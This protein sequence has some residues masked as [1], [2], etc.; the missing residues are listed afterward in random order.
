MADVIQKALYLP[1]EVY[2]A[3]KHVLTFQIGTQE[4]SLNSDGCKEYSYSTCT[5]TPSISG[6]DFSGHSFEA[7]VLSTTDS[8]SAGK[9]NLDVDTSDLSTGTVHVTISKAASIALDNFVPSTNS[10]STYNVG[11]WYLKRTDPSGYEFLEI[12]GKVSLN[13]ALKQGV[14]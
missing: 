8:T 5:G 4:F 6:Y 3:T 14:R 10:S 1:L 7:A 9:V 12:Y 2:Y 11:K 13:L